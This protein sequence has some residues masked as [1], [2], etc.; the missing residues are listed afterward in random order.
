MAKNEEAIVISINGEEISGGGV[1]RNKRRKRNGGING[2]MASARR[3]IG[4]HLVIVRCGAYQ[5]M[6][7]CGVI[8]A[9]Y[10]NQQ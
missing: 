2:G 4:Q 3:V 10:H 6:A 1:A 8:S 9:A 5:R 7:A